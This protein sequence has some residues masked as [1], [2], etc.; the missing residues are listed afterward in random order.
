MNTTLHDNEE[1]KS[2]LSIISAYFFSKRRER[3]VKSQNHET[4]CNRCLLFD[5]CMYCH[6]AKLL[7]SEEHFE[8][9]NSWKSLHIILATMGTYPTVGDLKFTPNIPHFI[10]STYALM[11]H[12]LS[13]TFFF[14]NNKLLTQKKLKRTRMIE[15]CYN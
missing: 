3:G 7:T 4:A 9:R 1:C 6:K 14:G 13:F 10:R 12:F 5:V 11:A 15:D 2:V 8:T